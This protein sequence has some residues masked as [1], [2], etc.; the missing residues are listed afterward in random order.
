MNS[1]AYR[2]DHCD[3][4]SRSSPSLPRVYK[5]RRP[6]RASF[7]QRAVERDRRRYSSINVSPP[8]SINY[9]VH[10][11][12]LY[13]PTVYIREATRTSRKQASANPLCQTCEIPSSVSRWRP[14]GTSAS[15]TMSK[16]FTT[17]VQSSRENTAF[18]DIPAKS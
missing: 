15:P 8:L 7:K 6:S 1:L 2:Q 12:T 11:R 14:R 13:L 3:S 5:H 18:R 4:S 9:Q 10:L 17:I 16:Y